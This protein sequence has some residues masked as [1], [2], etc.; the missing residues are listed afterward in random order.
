MGRMGV[1]LLASIFFTGWTGW[2]GWGA[3]CYS[4]FSLQDG[5]DGQDGGQEILEN[6]MERMGFGYVKKTRCEEMERYL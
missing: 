1:G 6:R 3:V 5:Q 2:T 4:P